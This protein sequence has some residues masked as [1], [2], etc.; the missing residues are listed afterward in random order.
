MES[1][2]FD[3]PQPQRS[4]GQ[5]REVNSIAKNSMTREAAARITANIQSKGGDRD[6]QSRIDSAAAKNDK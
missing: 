3:R 1:I 5:S 4:L 6:A 2:F